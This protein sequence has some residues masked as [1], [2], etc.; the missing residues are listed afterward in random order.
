[1]KPHMMAT[2][3]GHQW[4]AETT[5]GFYK[6]GQWEHA[7]SFTECVWSWDPAQRSTRGFLLQH[8][9]C[10]KKQLEY[11]WRTGSQEANHLHVYKSGLWIG[12][13]WLVHCL[14]QRGAKLESSIC[15]SDDLWIL[16]K[17]GLKQWQYV[18]D[19]KVQSPFKNS[20]NCEYEACPTFQN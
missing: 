16:K 17:F 5:Q 20:H 7:G 3:H 4:S 12:F 14:T 1:M 13:K 6:S 11:L 15:E 8:G 19:V 18:H 2:G 10:R 9:L